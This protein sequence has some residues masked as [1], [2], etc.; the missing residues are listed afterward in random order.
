MIDE[1]PLAVIHADLD[2]AGDIYR[3]HGWAEPPGEDTLFASG[4]ANFLDLMQSNR[5][6]ATLFTI[7]SSL[8]DRRKRELIGEALRRGHEIASHSLTHTHLVRLNREGKWR[9]I[10]DS[11]RKLEDALGVAIRGFRAPGYQLDRES[12]ELIARAGYEYDSSAFPTATHGRRLEAPVET[13]TAPHRPVEGSPLIEL[14]LPDH[15]PFP[16]P[17]SP[18]YALLAGPRF[19]RWGAGRIARR[20]R[21]LVLLFHLT[22][23]A[24]PL[25]PA[26]RRNWRQT[27]FTLS[28]MPARSKR[29]R[30]QAML[31]FVRS[32]FRLATTTEL[33]A[34][35][36]SREALPQQ[37]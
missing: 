18:S 33:L 30:C 4:L 25:P 26:A 7:A 14:P 15:R 20:G 32:R 1:R 23:L 12:L 2:G 29:V 16:V 6:Q 8:D 31:D 13:L 17:F 22:D 37:V 24:D 27:L 10:A 28:M 5:A 34:E 11:R 19:F 36:T 3:S 9:E 35:A 21:P